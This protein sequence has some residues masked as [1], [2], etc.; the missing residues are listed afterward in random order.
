MSA[1]ED[2][3][4]RRNAERPPEQRLLMGALLVKA[5]ALAARKFPAFNGFYRDGKF[6]AAPSVH[7]GTAIAIRGGGLI[8]PAIHDVDRQSLDDLM[9]KMRELGAWCGRVAAE[10]ADPPSPFK[11]RDQASR[12]TRHRL[13]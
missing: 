12:P 13:P 11:P 2:W 5:V 8:A 3:L 7:I 9:V 4:G 10:I 1:C 6:E